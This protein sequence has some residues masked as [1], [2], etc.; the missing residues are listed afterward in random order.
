MRLF[1]SFIIYF[2]HFLLSYS[3]DVLMTTK[4]FNVYFI[5]IPLW[6]IYDET[7]E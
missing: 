4:L 6:P 7:F 1:Y 3:R 2:E 5:M